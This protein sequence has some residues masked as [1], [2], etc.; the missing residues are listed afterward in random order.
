MRSASLLLFSLVLI[1]TSCEVGPKEIHY[2]ADACH[3][4]KMTIVDT[5]HAA[6][7]VTE[8]GK[9]FK[10]D[11]IECMLNHKA[12]WDQAAIKFHLVADYNNPKVLIDATQAHYLVSESIPSPMGAFLSA[13]ERGP[14]LAK[15]RTENGGE[16]YSWESLLKNFDLKK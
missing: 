6:Q 10:Y 9:A 5:Q 12:N 2:G 14:E 13:F 15:I 4:C 3:Y 7:L 16:T 11:A 1:F 8:K